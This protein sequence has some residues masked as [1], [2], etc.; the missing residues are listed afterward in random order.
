MALEGKEASA[1]SWLRFAVFVTPFSKNTAQCSTST[2]TTIE[3]NEGDVV[4]STVQAQAETKTYR[5]AT[6]RKGD[7][8]L[9]HLQRK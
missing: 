8:G 9:W 5:G 3:P 1:H 2:I 7:D 6:Y 4:L